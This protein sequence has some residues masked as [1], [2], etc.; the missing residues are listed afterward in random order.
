M[1][2]KANASAERDLLFETFRLFFFLVYGDRKISSYIRK[3]TAVSCS[4]EVAFRQV[5]EH[6]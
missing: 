2:E 1:V 4:H 6:C 3:V 5:E